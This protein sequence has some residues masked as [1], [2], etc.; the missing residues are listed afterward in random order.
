MLM[1]ISMHLV[2]IHFAFHL[3][4]LTVFFAYFRYDHELLEEYP[5]YTTLT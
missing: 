5:I 4:S 1:S 3:Y 2:W